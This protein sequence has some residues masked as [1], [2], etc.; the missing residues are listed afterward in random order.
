MTTLSMKN[1]AIAA[2]LAFSALAA[3]ATATT[4]DG[5]YTLG[6][7]LNT[8]D[9]SQFTFTSGAGLMS[10]WVLEAP[11]GSSLSGVTLDGV[12]AVWSHT[13]MFGSMDS[14]T[15][16]PIALNAGNHTIAISGANGSAFHAN[17]TYTDA[18][19]AAVPEPETYAML[20]AGLGALGF[21]ARRRKAQ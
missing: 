20:L 21:V 9:G 15:L 8:F 14:W 11:T 13:T 6:T 3:H 7:A 12:S 5:D 18:P 17:F 16:A 2:A 19:A 4:V 1:I 10:G